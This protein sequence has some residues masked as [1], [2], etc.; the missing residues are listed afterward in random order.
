M[1]V[2]SDWW[3]LFLGDDHYYWCVISDLEVKR[4]WQSH[5]TDMDASQN[6]IDKSHGM[7]D[8]VRNGITFFRTFRIAC[9]KQVCL[10]PASG[11]LWAQWTCQLTRLIN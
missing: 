5:M 3:V 11:K 6:N 2:I 1:T 7:Q 9:T 8:F 4:N 10:F